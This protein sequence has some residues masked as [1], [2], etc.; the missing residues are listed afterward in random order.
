MASAADQQ[1]PLGR[2][3]HLLGLIRFSHTIFALPF[4]ALATVMAITAPL[5]SDGSPADQRVTL[6]ITQLVGIVLCMV[7]AQHRDGV[8]SFGRCGV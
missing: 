5:P 2:L 6:G 1:H 8:Q 7:F 3:G 4:A